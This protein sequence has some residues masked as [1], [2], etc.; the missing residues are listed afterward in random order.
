MSLG[1]QILG[2][3]RLRRGVTVKRLCL[4]TGASLVDVELAVA[5]LYRLRLVTF[6]AMYIEPIGDL[7]TRADDEGCP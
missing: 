6:G 5:E 3:V 1:P 7:W 2:L 4:W